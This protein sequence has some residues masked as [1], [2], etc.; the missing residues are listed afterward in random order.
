MPVHDVAMLVIHVAC[1]APKLFNRTTVCKLWTRSFVWL[2]VVAI[3]GNHVSR[4]EQGRGV[5]CWKAMDSASKGGPTRILNKDADFM[6]MKSQLLEYILDHNH[7]PEVL[8]ELREETH[9]LQGS[10][11]QVAPEQARFM[12]WLA[13]TMKAKRAIEIGVYTGYSSIAVAL[14][15]PDDGQLIAIDKNKDSMAVAKKFFKKAG[16]DHKVSPRIGN[17]Q[18]EIDKVLEEE[19]PD[20]FDF[21]FI[22][23]DKFGNDAY[24]EAS[25]KL[26]RVG[27]AVVLDN[28]LWGGRVA[29]PE[30]TESSTIAI[31]DLNKKVFNDKRVSSTLLQ[32]GDGVMLCRKL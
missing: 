18:E 15:L 25:L 1:G 24:Y 29:D 11:M 8:S 10:I 31:R 26:L 17:G 14:A 32:I 20:S 9:K 2:F 3:K 16:I 6:S 27:G 23:A 12:T 21:V 13:E 5:C 30:N 4:S 19:G 7:E 28:M 22:D